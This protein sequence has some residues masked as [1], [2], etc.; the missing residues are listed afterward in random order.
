MSFWAKTP[1]GGVVLL[2]LLGGFAVLMVGRLVAESGA[3]FV[4]AARKTDRPEAA[5]ARAEKQRADE[6]S[7]KELKRRRAGVKAC[8]DAKKELAPDVFISD[9]LEARFTD[10]CIKAE[11]AGP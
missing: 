5:R 2:G 4:D 10:E 6:A 3:E 9:E 7:A 11:T 1:I 8:V